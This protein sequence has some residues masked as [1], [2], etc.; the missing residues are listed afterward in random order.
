VTSAKVGQ[1]YSFKPTAEDAD[2]DPLTFS[3]QNKPAWATFDT[4][5]GTLYGTPTSAN[6]S[7]F[8]N[9]VISVND[10]EVSASL[11][12]FAITVEAATTGSLTVSWVPPTQNTDGTPVTGLSGFRVSYGTASR[13]YDQSVLVSSPSLTSVVVEG[14]SPG[15]TWY[16]AV[17]SVND[18]GVESEYTNEAVATLL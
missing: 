4:S 5:D 12:A 10:G 17:K 18:T 2:G 11:P 15:T 1:P 14:L 6:V 9:I 16:F 8:A 13:Q 3:I 7:T